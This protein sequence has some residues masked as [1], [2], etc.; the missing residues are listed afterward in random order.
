MDALSR[1]NIPIGGGGTI[2][3]ATTM[4]TGP[5]WRLVV[6]LSKI[7]TPKGYGVYPGGQSGNPGSNHYDDLI[8]TWAKGE[9]K[10]LLYMESATQRSTRIRKK[11]T[12][13]TK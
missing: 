12:L 9:L 8:D 1:L 7:G 4:R 5:S 6:E 13:E 3:N 11:I 10:P 2:V